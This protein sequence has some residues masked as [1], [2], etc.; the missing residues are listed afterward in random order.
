MIIHSFQVFFFFFG[1]VESV[2]NLL[3]SIPRI[4]VMMNRITEA[5]AEKP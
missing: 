5:A 4:T 2:L 3:I 1:A